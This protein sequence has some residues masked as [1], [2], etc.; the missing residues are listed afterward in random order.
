M[1]RSQCAPQSAPKRCYQNQQAHHARILR[2]YHAPKPVCPAKCP[3]KMLSESTGS[4]CKNTAY[5]SCTEA[6][7]PRKVRQTD[8]III[9][10][11]I[12]HECCICDAFTQ[13]TP[14]SA[15]EDDRGTSYHF[16]PVAISYRTTRTTSSWLVVEPADHENLVGIATVTGVCGQTIHFKIQCVL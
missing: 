7:V 5:I 13:G 4:S 8:A 2:I 6:S 16:D 9:N 10:R 12:I 15:Q 1:H 14:L 3:K 11:L